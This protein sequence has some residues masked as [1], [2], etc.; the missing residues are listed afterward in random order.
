MGY[1]ILPT[2]DRVKY[3][4]RPGL[5]GPF[6]TRIGQPVYYDPKVGSYY[7]PDKDVYLTYEEWR[8][9]D[10]EKQMPWKEVK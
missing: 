6:Q 7:H 10:L 2:L 8:E 5:E 4:E 3:Q 1:Y 9:L